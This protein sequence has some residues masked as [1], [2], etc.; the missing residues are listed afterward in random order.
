MSLWR[1]SNTHERND[2]ECIKKQ[3]QAEDMNMVAYHPVDSRL[4]F[5]EDLDQRTHHEIN[6]HR[7]D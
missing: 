5:L 7:N 3:E 6:R 4:A 2:L 1:E